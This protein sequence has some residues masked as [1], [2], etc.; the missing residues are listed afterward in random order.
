MIPSQYKLR[1]Y[2]GDSFTVTLI[3]KADGSPVDLTGKIIIAQ[4]REST[5]LDAEKLFDFSQSVTPLEGRVILSLS[6]VTTKLVEAGSYA[7]DI[8][9]DDR[10]YL[11]GVFELVA[12][13][14]RV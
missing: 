5:D 7:W 2:R 8:Q 3:F 14:S 12:D 11:R 4:V 1:A 6:P 9:L 10:T 13:V